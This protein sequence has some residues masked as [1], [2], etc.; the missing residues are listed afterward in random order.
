VRGE[1][2]YA[3]GA[4]DMKGQVMASIAA[5][6]AVAR[7]GP[8]PV[9]VKFL[10]EGEEEIGSPSLPAFLAAHTDRLRA[11]ISLNPDAGMIARTCRPSPTGCGAWPTSSCGSTGRP[12]T[13]TPASTAAWSTTRP[14]SSAS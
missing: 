14:R 8:L 4:S 9:H 6:E 10:I 2:L 5:F 3:R 1:N 13:C 7:S 11:T 12:T